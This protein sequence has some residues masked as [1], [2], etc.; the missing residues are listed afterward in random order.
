MQTFQLG[1]VTLGCD[2]WALVSGPGI[3][4]GS[5]ALK[6]AVTVTELLGNPLLNFFFLILYF[7]KRLP[8][9]LIEL[10]VACHPLMPAQAQ[11][12]ALQCLGPASPV[13]IDNTSTVLWVS[14]PAWC[15]CFFLENFTRTFKR[16]HLKTLGHRVQ[17]LESK[18]PSI[19]F[20]STTYLAV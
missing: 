5:L 18:S 20:D 16:Y 12:P 9:E 13:G 17:V 15:W 2:T 6:H 19:K 1:H 8:L 14:G 7:S 11:R 4:P 10:Y 3:K